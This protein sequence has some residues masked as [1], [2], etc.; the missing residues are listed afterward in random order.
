MLLVLNKVV[1]L[2]KTADY[3][4][5]N[6]SIWRLGG[7]MAIFLLST[8]AYFIPNVISAS[9]DISLDVFIFEEDF[10]IFWF[11]PHVT[12]ETSHE[13]HSLIVSSVSY[14]WS[15]FRSSAANIC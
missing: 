3:Y 7:F 11:A 14:N 6:I 2:P 9:N 15:N 8:P 4:T 10:S 5:M 12:C 13:F 1:F